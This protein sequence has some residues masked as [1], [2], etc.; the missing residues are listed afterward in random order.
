MDPQQLEFALTNIVSSYKKAN[1]M[2][3]FKAYLARQFSE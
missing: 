3:D 2:L 1:G